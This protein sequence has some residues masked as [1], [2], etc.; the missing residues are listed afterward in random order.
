GGPDRLLPAGRRVEAEPLQRRLAARA[1][2]APLQPE[3]ALLRSGAFLL[4]LGIAGMLVLASGP[5]DVLGR[6]WQIHTM[7]AF[8]ALT[9]IGAQVVQ[10][11][12][13]AR[14]YALTHFGERDS[15][16]ERLRGH[17][18]LEH[19]VLLGLALFLAGVA[20]ILV[21]VVRWA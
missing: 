14:T 10:I 19:G 18:R 21:V 17:V 11:G 9:L 12:L 1:L 5:V 13:F 8:V 15:L 6:T 2:H 3:L 16:L 7:L 4:V 20:V